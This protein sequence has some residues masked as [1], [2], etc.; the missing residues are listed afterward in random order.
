MTVIR[1][2]SRWDMKKL[3]KKTPHKTTHPKFA[4]LLGV[5]RALFVSAPYAMLLTSGQRCLEERPECTNDSS[6]GKGTRQG[7]WM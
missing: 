4:K 5:R 6:R 2:R 3:K 1:E 7:L